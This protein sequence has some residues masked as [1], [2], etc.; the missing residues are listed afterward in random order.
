VR[1]T[2]ARGPAERPGRPRVMVV[3]PGTRGAGGIAVVI[4][5]LAASPLADRY[6]LVMVATHK[7]SGPMGKAL[8]ALA[9]SAR[10]AALLAA[11]RVDL[12]YLHSSSGPSLLRK[13]AVAALARLARRPYVIHV[14]GGAFDHYYREAAGW[15]R[16]IVRNTLSGAALVIALS[17][18]WERRLRVI[19]ACHTTAIPNPVPI[20]DELAHLDGRPAR[21]VC[22]GR[23]GDTKGSR[24]L[25]RALAALG[26]RHADVRLVLAGDGDVTAVR[27]EARRLGVSDRVELPGWI[28][29]EERARTLRSATAFALPSRAEGVPVALLEAMAYGLPAVVS[30]VGGIPDVF[31]ERRH[32]YF[33]PPDDPQALADRLRALLDNPQAARRMGARASRDAQERYSTDVVAAQV[34]DALEAALTQYSHAGR[35]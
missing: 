21:I 26:Q 28:G 20:P 2:G 15:E 34:G 29:A 1:Q 17:P 18:I 30:P 13:A 10:A 22:L 27:D 9:G 5:S 8:Q 24:T 25:V 3:G 33:A 6:E 4:G 31:E 14:H 23:L 11:R 32:G 7:D 35:S 19:A 16:S 12:V